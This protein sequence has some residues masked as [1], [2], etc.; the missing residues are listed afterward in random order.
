MPGTGAPR[1]RLL[2][3]NRTLTC[4]APRSCASPR[5]LRR[6][7]WL[8]LQPHDSPVGRGTPH[9][10]GGLGTSCRAEDR[11]GRRCVSFIGRWCLEMCGLRP[12]RRGGAGRCPV[13]AGGRRVQGRWPAGAAVQRPGSGS[14][15][16]PGPQR[17]A[18]K[19][20]CLLRWQ[21]QGPPCPS[22]NVL[23]PRPTGAP[24]PI[25]GLLR[26]CGGHDPSPLLS[27]G[28]LSRGRGSRGWSRTWGGLAMGGSS[29][30]T[31]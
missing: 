18:S 23:R 27:P 24:T 16:T 15:D 2:P 30:D 9:R 10:L 11:E 12:P 5:S 28:P 14:T 21:R 7:P 1:T 29:Q 26:V 20:R 8:G 6:C 25:L 13:T 22:R 17:G 3:Q 4:Q 19:P 31:V